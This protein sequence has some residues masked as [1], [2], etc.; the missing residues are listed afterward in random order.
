MKHRFDLKNQICMFY[1]EN[2]AGSAP[3]SPGQFD[4]DPLRLDWRQVDYWEPPARTDNDEAVK[5]C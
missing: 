2:S 5:C 3:S 4:C 1:F